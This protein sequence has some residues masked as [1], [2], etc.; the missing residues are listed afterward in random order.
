LVRRRKKEK[1]NKKVIEWLKK[2]KFAEIAE[3]LPKSK[4]V[5]L[6]NQ[7]ICQQVGRDWL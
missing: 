6:V 3:G 2:H 7:Q 5:P 1:E 4:Y